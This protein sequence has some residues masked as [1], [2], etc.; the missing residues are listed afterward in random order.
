MIEAWQE[1]RRDYDIDTEL[2]HA[3]EDAEKMKVTPDA[4]LSEAQI[5]A[6]Q[7][8]ADLANQDTQEAARQYWW[9]VQQFHDKKYNGVPGTPGENPIRTQI[10]W[11]R[12]L[13]PTDRDCELKRRGF[14]SRREWE[15]N[16]MSMAGAKVPLLNTDPAKYPANT[17]L[18]P[19]AGLEPD[20][21]WKPKPIGSRPAYEDK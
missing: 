17:K 7:R 2:K 18:W 6:D 8:G 9:P 10:D 13:T 15:Q 20:S 21:D 5:I 14:W 4:L 1:L 16:R 3:A 11:L 19:N 12:G